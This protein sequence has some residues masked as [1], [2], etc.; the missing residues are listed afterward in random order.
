DF[1]G[2][3]LWK[4]EFGGFISQH[5]A[6]ASPVVYQ[7][8]VFFLNDQDKDKESKKK[9]PKEKGGPSKLLALDGKTG[10]TVWEVERQPHRACYA[11]PFLL[12]R[13]DGRAELILTT[14]T[15]VHGYDPQNGQENWVWHWKFTGMLLRMVGSPLYHQGLLFLASGDGSGERHFAC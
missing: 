11:A 7:G 9:G 3:Q 13:P 12:E 14:T 6:G 10:Q 8:K 5:G 4:R 1:K 15:G 2:N